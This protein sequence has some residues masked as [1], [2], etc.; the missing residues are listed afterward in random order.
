MS[1][2]VLN[3]CGSGINSSKKTPLNLTRAWVGRCNIPKS[4]KWGRC[5][6]RE[7]RLEGLA[8]T[9]LWLVPKRGA[10]CLVSLVVF[11]VICL[12]ILMLLLMAFR[13]WCF[14]TESPV[15]QREDWRE[16]VTSATGHRWL[17]NRRLSTLRCLSPLS[18]PA[19]G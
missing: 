4:P 10:R 7:F 17:A 1:S 12:P 15:S 13:W 5:I 16:C 9:Q 6:K 11:P 18:V 19:G 3:A 14:Q 2:G 8:I